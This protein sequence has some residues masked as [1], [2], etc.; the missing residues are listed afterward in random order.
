MTTETTT[1]QSALT[2]RIVE[3]TGAVLALLNLIRRHPG[4]AAPY[5]TV[6]AP[7]PEYDAPAKLDMQLDTPSDFEAW[8]S[9]LAVDPSGVALHTSASSV[10]LAA[11]TWHAGT[12]VHLSGFNVPLT[13]T[14]AEAPRDR[15]EVAA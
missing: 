14:H 4:L 10:W 11:D 2:D 9:A 1:Q 5:I 7:M 15:D 3:Q 12:R 13:R 8:R 6:H